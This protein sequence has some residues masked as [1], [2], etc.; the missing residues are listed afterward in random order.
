MLSLH[1]LRLITNVAA[2]I[3]FGLVICDA[4]WDTYPPVDRMTDTC[5]NITF[6]QTLFAGGKKECVTLNE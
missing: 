6:P 1:L 4:C 5:K 2:Y 3:V